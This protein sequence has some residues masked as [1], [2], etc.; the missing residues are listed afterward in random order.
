MSK[1]LSPQAQAVMDAY[2]NS[3]PMGMG[4]VLPDA[5]GVAAALRAAATRL[6][7]NKNQ[8]YQ[9]GGI[10]AARLQLLAIADELE[11]GG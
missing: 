7:C 1:P 9:V 11:A 4:V 5:A 3:D 8:S 2:H 6:R 10:I